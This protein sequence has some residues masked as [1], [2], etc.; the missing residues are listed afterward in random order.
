MIR[1][2]KGDAKKQAIAATA[3]N[4]LMVAAFAP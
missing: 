1:P 3:N 2:T 4:K